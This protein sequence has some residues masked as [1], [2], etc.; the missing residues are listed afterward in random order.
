M[1]NKRNL[2]G[3]SAGPGV[4][5]AVDVEALLEDDGA[6]WGSF[7]SPLPLVVPVLE[8]C[9]LSRCWAKQDEP[10]SFGSDNCAIVRTCDKLTI[11][12]ER[13]SSK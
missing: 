9:W 8:A 3:T 6:L 2:F 5:L 1:S 12:F 13:H 11:S 4:E 10:E 7:G